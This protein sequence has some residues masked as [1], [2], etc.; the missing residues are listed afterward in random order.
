MFCASLRKRRE[1]AAAVPLLLKKEHRPWQEKKMETHDIA[2]PMSGNGTID[3]GGVFLCL[4]LLSA[5][6]LKQPQTME[7]IERLFYLEVGRRCAIVFLLSTNDNDG[8]MSAFGRLQI[9]IMER[10]ISIPI[11]PLT[12][13]DELPAR[14]EA[15]RTELLNPRRSKLRYPGAEA[16]TLLQHS[17]LNGPLPELQTEKLTELNTNFGDLLDKMSTAQGQAIVQDYVPDVADRVVR[18][19]TTESS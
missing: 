16:K 6:D 14:L 17:S 5:L 9:E 1:W 11:L 15:F 18:F 8:G 7:R 4:V 12:S 13:V 3:G 10:F 19:W 2:M